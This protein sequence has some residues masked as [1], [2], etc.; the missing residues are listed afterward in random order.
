MHLDEGDLY[1]GEGVAK[2]HA[3]VGQPSRIDDNPRHAL[4]LCPLNA[5]DQGPFV[6]AL[7]GFFSVDPWLTRAQQIEIGAVQNQNVFEPSS[8]RTRDTLEFRHGRKFDAVRSKL[9]SI[10]HIFELN[11][12]LS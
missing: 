10:C 9:S 6:D 11:E 5:F 12:R 8:W 2:R 7:D 1:R 4:L 3:G